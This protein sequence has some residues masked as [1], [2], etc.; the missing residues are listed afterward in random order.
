MCDHAGS[1]A[2]RATSDHPISEQISV[3]VGRLDALFS[4]MRRVVVI[5]G[6]SIL[7]LLSIASIG[8]L[9]CSGWLV[10][11]AEYG[12]GVPAEREIAELPA[13]GHVCAGHSEGAYVA[14]AEMPALVRKAVLASDD[15]DFYE[16]PLSPLSQLALALA[17][18]R[19]PTSS[20]ISFA[21]TRLCLFAMRPTCCKGL[22]WHIGSLV[23][24]D[25]LT[26]ALS[27]DRILEI[28]I[29]DSYFGRGAYGV[30]AA[31]RAYF[32]KTLGQL[33]VDEVAFLV[34]RIRGPS[35]PVRD[36]DKMRRDHV[37]ERMVAAGVI[38]DAE[39]IAAKARPLTLQEN[40]PGTLIKSND[41]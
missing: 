21:V 32:G 27:R 28:C 9:A 25:R 41:P 33:E 4:A 23:F 31:A 30:A 11:H 38:S 3:A 13:T 29:N 34:S 18:G 19:P 40:Q 10:W 17:A 12:I 26:K 1:L 20:N 35:G 7:A 37:I 22:D 15:P 2:D 6:K 5:L 24:M 39:G 14:L 8:L 36:Y 16:R